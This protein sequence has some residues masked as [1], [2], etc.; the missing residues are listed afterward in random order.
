MWREQLY[1]S[2]NVSAKIEALR[3]LSRFE[4]PSI[5]DIFFKFINDNS[6]TTELRAEAMFCLAS[7]YYNKAPL[8]ATEVEYDTFKKLEKLSKDLFSTQQQNCIDNYILQKAFIISL[9]MIKCKNDNQHPQAISDM[10]LSI[11]EQFISDDYPINVKPLISI[12]LQALTSIHPPLP[13]Y[14]QIEVQ[15]VRYLQNFDI[16]KLYN[17]D[18]IISA[19]RCYTALY[20]LGG[21]SE[22]SIDTIS[23]IRFLDSSY[24]SCIR[25]AAIESF[26]RLN[27]WFGY[28]DAENAKDSLIFI[29]NF[30]KKERN[31]EVKYTALEQ[32]AGINNLNIYKY[33]YRRF[34]DPFYGSFNLKIRNELLKTDDE[35]NKII[36]ELFWYL[37]NERFKYD[38]YACRLI[39]QTYKLFYGTTSP[40]VLNPKTLKITKI[41]ELNHYYKKIYNIYDLPRVWYN[42]RRVDKGKYKST[43]SIDK[44]NWEVYGMQHIR[45]IGSI[46]SNNTSI[47]FH[48]NSSIYSS[49]TRR[50]REKSPVNQ[51][52]V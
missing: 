32:L 43:I 34:I 18:D 11:T 41:P 36:A 45:P 22:D 16:D 42:D 13:D 33:P 15:I 8:N 49:S 44:L 19:I 20:I 2:E 31:F 4:D 47:T 30:I 46:T 3:C 24:R 27:V 51:A 37:L 35:K 6:I 14:K 17:N 39:Y 23:I 10:L 48:R 26:I 50:H 5:E 7:Y 52:S 9:T 38:S 25:A 29:L 12:L 21:L 1:R 40:Q 28:N